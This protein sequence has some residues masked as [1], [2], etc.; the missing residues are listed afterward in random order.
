MIHCLA[1]H[2]RTVK[3]AEKNCTLSTRFLLIPAEIA[4]LRFSSSIATSH[5]P[6]N[7]ELKPIF[8][9]YCFT[10]SPPN[11]LLNWAQN[12]QWL[13][14]KWNW[15]TSYIFPCEFITRCQCVVITHDVIWVSMLNIFPQTPVASAPHFWVLSSVFCVTSILFR[16]DSRLVGPWDGCKDIR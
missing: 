1:K 11:L 9:R 7:R 8:S 6:N 16:F 14:W 12:E 13:S 2:R 4:H 3:I 10:Y 5:T 15:A